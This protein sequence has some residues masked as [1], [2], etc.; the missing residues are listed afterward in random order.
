MKSG[1][2]HGI[3]AL[4]LGLSLLKNAKGNPYYDSLV[5]GE[6]GPGTKAAIYD[7]ADDLGM[8]PEERN[9]TTAD[10]KRVLVFSLAE[11]GQKQISEHFKVREFACQDG[12]DTVFIHPVLPEWAEAIRK[13]NGPF[14]PTSAYRTVTHNKAIGGAEFSRHCHGTAMDIPA[15][16]AD[17]QTLFEA[18]EEILGESGGLG[19][20]TWGIHMDCRT[21]KARWK[22]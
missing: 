5:D 2:Y 21:E 9:L 8:I 1:N 17:P 12:S 15:V 4:Q 20:Y 14:S 7:L 16:N 19:L 6:V 13:I 3:V 22:E 18:A 11:D 10:E